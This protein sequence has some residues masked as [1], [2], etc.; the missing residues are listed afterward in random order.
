EEAGL[1]RIAAAPR[2]APRLAHQVPASILGASPSGNPAMSKP[3]V[4]VLSLL[5]L[6]AAS[7]AEAQAT[8]PPELAGLD[9]TVES[10]RDTFK[11]PGVAVAVVKDGKVVFSGG[12]GEREAGKPE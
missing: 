7:P 4:A 10:V 12:W 9:A 1:S 3:L 5:L 2:P 6:S 11:V 8:P